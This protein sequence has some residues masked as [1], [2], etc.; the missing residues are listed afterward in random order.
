[1]EKIQIVGVLQSNYVW[2]VRM[3]LRG[4]GRARRRLPRRANKTAQ[5]GRIACR[6]LNGDAD[7]SLFRVNHATA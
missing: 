5:I 6:A 3:G 7:K 4:E 2:V 1:M